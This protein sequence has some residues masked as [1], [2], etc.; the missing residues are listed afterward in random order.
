MEIGRYE[1]TLWK[2][3]NKEKEKE[4]LETYLSNPPSQNSV[5]V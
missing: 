2:L 4:T 1:A 5:F 3:K